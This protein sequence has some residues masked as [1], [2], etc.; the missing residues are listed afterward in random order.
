MQEKRENGMQN[1]R[2]SK[3]EGNK[4]QTEIDSVI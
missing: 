3:K 4:R 1:S 2:S